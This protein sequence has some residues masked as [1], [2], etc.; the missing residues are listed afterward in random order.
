M[1]VTL[2]FLVYYEIQHTVFHGTDKMSAIVAQSP[3]PLIETA[4]SNFYDRIRCNLH[5][6]IP[7]FAK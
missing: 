1:S 7:I 2:Y 3:I 5:L 6:R 4:W